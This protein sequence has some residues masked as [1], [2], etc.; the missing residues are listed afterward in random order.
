MASA[1]TN[2]IMVLSLD[3]VVPDPEQPRQYFD[4]EAMERL[5]AGILSVGQ[6]QPIR[7]RRVGKRWMIVDGQRR[8]LS[9]CS[10]AKQFPEDE[11]FRTISAFV[12]GELDED[13]A[14]R[15]AVQVLSNCGEDLRPTEKAAALLEIRRAEP[16]LKVEEIG[17]RLGVP[18]GQVQLLQQ[19]ATAS[20]FLKEL[21][22][23]AEALPLWNLV[24]LVRVH[25]KLRKW[26]DEQFREREGAHER[27]ADREVRKLGERAR[28]GSWGKRRLQAEA[29]RLVVRITR[30][31]ERAEAKREPLASIR[32]WLSRVDDLPEG[33]R[34]QLCELLRGALDRLRAPARDTKERRAAKAVE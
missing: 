3:E 19:L 34:D 23:G 21:G 5:R 26:D 13:R 11:R 22:S 4:R 8:W 9:L 15:L 2:E 18:T 1:M 12:G 28:E 24:T 16:K 31:E 25:R 17:R 32:M 30:N 7:V 10:L 33:E 6:L 27:V 14:S 20:N 29:E